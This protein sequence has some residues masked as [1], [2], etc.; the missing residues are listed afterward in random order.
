MSLV[1]ENT[2]AVPLHSTLELELRGPRKFASMNNPSWTPTWHAMD[3]VSWTLQ[4]LA[5]LNLF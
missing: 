5:T 1:V 4:N 2:E 3:N